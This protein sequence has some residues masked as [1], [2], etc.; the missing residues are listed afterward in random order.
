MR[1]LKGLSP[2]FE[3]RTESG[4]YVY[5]VGLFNTYAD[6]LSKLNTVKKVGFKNAY[7]VG[8]V[9]GKEMKVTKVREQEN[10][11]KKVAPSFYNVI[12]VPDAAAFDDV[13]MEAVVQ[14]A[15][16]KDVARLEEEGRT[17]YSVGPFSNE[18]EA[19]K[20]YLFVNGMGY[21]KASVTKVNHK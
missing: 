10:I 13:A 5:R 18:A 8:Y 19:E 21:G 14:Q 6:V 7:I 1:S 2:V 16:G 9:D 12:I 11:R 17:I 20:I 3:S 4:R 15:G